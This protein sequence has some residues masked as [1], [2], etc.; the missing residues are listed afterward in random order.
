MLKIVG[1]I[2][3]FLASLMIVSHVVLWWYGDTRLNVPYLI[4]LVIAGLMCA[5]ALYL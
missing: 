2:C 4:G 3:V 1:V 5:G